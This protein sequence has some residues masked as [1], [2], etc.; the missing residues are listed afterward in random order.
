MNRS[1]PQP[2]PDDLD[3]AFSQYFRAQMPAR[4]PAPP[5]PAD[6]ATV[7]RTAG[8]W[9]T[10]LTLGASVAALLALGFA[11]S[12]GPAL[13]HPKPQNHG[14]G[15]GDTADGDKMKKLMQDPPMQMMP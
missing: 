4:W 14:I 3:R 15:S 13:G 8:P 9:R 7:A 10:R 11:V 2:S 1:S 6:A 12:Y 5:V